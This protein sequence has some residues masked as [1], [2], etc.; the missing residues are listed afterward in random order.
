[1][2]WDTWRSATVAARWA[3]GR[4]RCCRRPPRP[5]RPPDQFAIPVSEAW[6]V[7]EIDDSEWPFGDHLSPAKAGEWAAVR[8]KVGVGESVRGRVIARRPFGVFV[9][10]GVGFPASLDAVIPL[11]AYNPN[12]PGLALAYDSLA[13][14]PRPIV[15]EHHTLDDSLSTPT[16]VSG[17]LSFNGTAGT[18]WYYDTSQFIPGDVQQIALQTN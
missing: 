6:Y 13:A 7:N 17:Q 8:T 14:D 15:V 2:S 9:D 18:A 5:E 3:C 11:P 12:L 4:P 1:M 16:K 10:I